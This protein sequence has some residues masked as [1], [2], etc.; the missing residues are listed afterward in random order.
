[1]PALFHLALNTCTRLWQLSATVSFIV[2]TTLTVVLVVPT[3]CCAFNLQYWV[4]TSGSAE[5]LAKREK[6]DAAAQLYRDAMK[7]AATRGEDSIFYLLSIRNLARMYRMEHK[8]EEA[9]ALHKKDV[10]ILG[11]L[12]PDCPEL[13]ESVYY[14]GEIAMEENRLHDAES[15]L[16]RAL[17]IAESPAAIQSRSPS[18]VTVLLKL[19]KLYYE[20]DQFEKVPPILDKTE[21]VVDPLPYGDS[22]LFSVNQTLDNLVHYFSIQQEKIA[23]GQANELLRK[24]HEHLT[25][26]IMTIAKTALSRME[27]EQVADPAIMRRVLESLLKTDSINRWLY[28]QNLPELIEDLDGPKESA[29]S[30]YINRGNLRCEHNQLEQA[31]D[32]YL[33]AIKLLPNQGIAYFFLGNWYVSKNKPLDALSAYNKALTL[34]RD[35]ATFLMWRGH[36][37]RLSGRFNDALTDYTKS[38]KQG[39]KDPSALT[40]RGHVQLALG[41]AKAA[42]A[43][44]RAALR[45]A[46]DNWLVLESLASLLQSTNQLDESLKLLNQV[47]SVKGR[48]A[49]PYIQR[50][51]ILLTKGERA[52]ALADCKQAE[53]LKPQGEWASRLKLAVQKCQQ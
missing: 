22:Y 17:Q 49:V 43:D 45:L 31:R 24:N 5:K 40:G 32:D 21:R 27:K 50:A 35:D 28:Y 52:K 12:S 13:L 1:M 34:N 11:R 47:L 18:K 9:A 39:I 2:L 37:N 10:T 25:R 30:A 7:E 3:E 19:L 16:L 46:P 44:Y 26:T 38:I 41:N 8:W 48:N 51:E 6:W 15:Y 20:Q 33:H 42:E 29:F 23:A 53:T 14:L 4:Q 36:A